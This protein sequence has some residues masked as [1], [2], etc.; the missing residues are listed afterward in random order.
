M[1]EEGNTRPRE[2]LQKKPD[3]GPLPPPQ[4]RSIVFFSIATFLFWIALY[5]YVPILPVYA[6]SLGASLS[7]VGIVVASY[8]VPQLLLRIPIGIMY[9]VISR[10]KLLVA[11]GIAITSAGALGLGLAPNPWLLTLARAVT[12]IGAATWVTFTVYFTGYYQQERTGRAIGVINF[13]QRSALVV[14]TSCGG[15]IAEVQGF[16]SVFFIAAL[17]GVVALLGL[18]FAREP[19]GV[20]VQTVAPAGFMRVAAHPLLLMASFMAVLLQ[21]SSFAI[22]FGFMP[23]YASGIGAS[24]VELGII[25]MIAVG[26][27]AVASLVAVHMAERYGSTFV[28][29]LGAVL[30]GIS[31]LAIP[32]IRHVF[33]LEA[34]MVTYGLGSGVLGTILMA[35]SIRSV[36]PQQR[37]T[38][39]GVYQ[40]VYAVGMLF[41]PL[42]SGFVGDNLGLASVFYLSASLCLV[43]VGLAFMPVISRR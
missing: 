42:L 33:I 10:R 17:T 28:I 7:M 9:D 3:G 20:R 13:V 5:I 22:I 11:G 4:R 25:T 29:I 38:A 35:L 39:M 37:A 30:V 12:G 6:Q 27:S 15:A 2:P 31:T 8:A 19:A 43:I 18:L 36:A 26:S 34:V 14:A 32:F 21:F 40:A 23:V 1:S 16:T 24:S 41:G